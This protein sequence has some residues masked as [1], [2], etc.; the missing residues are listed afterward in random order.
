MGQVHRGQ[1]KNGQEVVIKVIK[2][3]FRDR[4]ISDVASLRRFVKTIL[5]F[6]PKLEKVADPLGIIDTIE[7]GTD[8]RLVGGDSRRDLLFADLEFHSIQ[9]S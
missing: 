9:V 3:D 6:Y 4:F 2:A 8:P 5:F 1:L 7:S